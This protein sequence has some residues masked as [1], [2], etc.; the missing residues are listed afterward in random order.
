MW[1]VFQPSRKVNLMSNDYKNSKEVNKAIASLLSNETAFAAA[2]RP[3]PNTRPPQ[4]IVDQA[5]AMR[6]EIASLLTTTVG[7]RFKPFVDIFTSA[8]HRL[9]EIYCFSLDFVLV[10]DPQQT[11]RSMVPFGISFRNMIH[12]I[13]EGKCQRADRGFVAI[14]SFAYLA[15]IYDLYSIPYRPSIDGPGLLEAAYTH[16]HRA[17]CL[18]AAVGAQREVDPEG[19]EILDAVLRM[20]AAPRVDLERVARIQAVVRQA[21]LA[22][23]TL[24][25]QACRK[26]TSVALKDVRFAG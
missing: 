12:S 18:R 3:I 2:Y 20:H 17:S 13:S 4:A 19:G 8:N 26:L 15:G 7:V 25:I 16:R 10:D 22:T 5:N 14:C 21:N 24:W 9:M 6:L 11:V 1:C 23:E